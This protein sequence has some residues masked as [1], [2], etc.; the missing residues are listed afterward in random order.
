MAR[1][2]SGTLNGPFVLSLADPLASGGSDD[3][4]IITSAGTITAT[5][6]DGIDGPAGTT[7]TIFNNGVVSATSGWGIAL[8]GA[9]LIYNS[10]L[11]GPG[12]GVEIGGYGFVANQGEIA[13]VAIA[14]G[15]DIINDGSIGP[16]L[17]ADA[18]AISGGLGII[19]NSGEIRGNDTG[20]LL[21]DGG[22]VTNSGGSISG[23]FGG[24]IIN[25]TG[26]VTNQGG[27]SSGAGAGG[28][29]VE[30]TDGV[31]SNQGSIWGFANGI[32]LGAGSVTNQGEITGDQEFGVLVGNGGSVRNFGTI[33]GSD[34][35]V[36]GEGGFISVTNQGLIEG[37]GAAGPP[38][39]G[40]ELSQ[41]SVA[42]F[43]TILST[44]FGVSLG[45]GSVENTTMISSPSTSGFLPGAGVGV[46]IGDGSVRNLGTILGGEV[47]VQ[48]GKGVVVNQ[49]S[50][51][52][53]VEIT[54]GPGTVTNGGLISF[55]ARH[56]GISVLFDPET[57]NNRLVI[58]PGAV[59]DGAAA[60]ASGTNSTIELAGGNGAISG[61]GKGQFDGFD[62]L[63]ADFGSNWTLNG[64]DTIGT[65][66]NDG[67]LAVAGSLDVTTALAPGSVGLFQLDG[68]SVLEI[69]S[70]LGI[71][72]KISFAAGSSLL[73]DN[74]SL[75]GEDVGTSGYAGPLLESFGGSAID[76]KSF[77]IAGLDQNFFAPS[78]LLQL[79][80]SASQ[81]ATLKFQTSSLGA[82]TFHFN[83]DG[84]GGVLI[85]HA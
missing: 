46:A 82:G 19:V 7:R 67:S 62:T 39:V 68:A 20:V 32:D 14:G 26:M 9:G 18:V 29:G 48:L 13:S 11:I 59:F 10:G 23:V 83:S 42:N 8:V 31:I 51:L 40:V 77:G 60:A 80:N 79:S 34:G 61:I 63:N 4:L 76:L 38:G 73:I 81:A 15:G 84:A 41:G 47:G 56:P 6:S 70:A 17:A 24:A 55:G 43:G 12:L 27:I 1:V 66:L 64:T 52:G 37:N 33:V 72:A 69:A 35:G 28:V 45:E 44:S 3:P 50:I 74:F 85:T 25:G 75:F 22:V 16:G 71:N 5:G 53:G 78:G 36:M 65:V 57:A 49:G 2:I 54:G 58:Q 30:I 21:S